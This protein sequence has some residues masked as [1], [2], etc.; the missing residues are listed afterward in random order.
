MNCLLVFRKNFPDS[1]YALGAEYYLANLESDADKRKARFTRYLK[2]SPGGNLAPLILSQIIDN[3]EY[4][5]LKNDIAMVYFNLEDYAKAI[6]YFDTSSESFS[7]RHYAAYAKTLARNK[8]N[9]QSKNFLIEKIQETTD[10]KLASKLLNAVLTLGNNVADL[11]VL[12]SLL[13][14]SPHIEDEILWKIAERTKSKLD[15]QNVYSKFPDSYYAAESMSRVFWIEYKRKSFH[16]AKALFEKHWKSYPETRSHPFVAFWMAKLYLERKDLDSARAVLNN[17]VSA[18]PLNYYSYRAK[19]LL[20]G[21]KVNNRWDWFKLL[22]K[23]KFV[24]VPDW[25][26]PELFSEEQIQEL[27]GE[28]IKELFIT[29]SY[30]YILSIDKFKEVLLIRG[31]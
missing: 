30:D 24:H 22:P 25:Q 7:E 28:D 13:P 20:K 27:Y 8:E 19:D 6:K 17:L 2:E 11:Y 29:K 1:D 5:F 26:R 21:L 9:L 15:Y 16:L 31:F 14:N 23:S 12:R 3:S 18:H 4:D 10:V